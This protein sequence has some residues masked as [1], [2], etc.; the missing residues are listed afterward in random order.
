[1]LAHISPAHS[2]NINFF[3]SIDVDIFQVLS[4]SSR[5]PHCS[6]RFSALCQL[7]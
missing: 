1:V 7:A 5:G 6:R 4:K 2:E 3:G